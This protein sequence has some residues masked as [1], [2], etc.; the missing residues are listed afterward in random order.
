MWRIAAI[1]SRPDYHVVERAR[2]QSVLLFYS[3][4]LLFGF[5]VF[6]VVGDIEGECISHPLKMIF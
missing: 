2:Q 4:Y 1:R 6:E 5:S 3:K